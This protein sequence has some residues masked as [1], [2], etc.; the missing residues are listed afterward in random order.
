MGLSLRVAPIV[1]LRVVLQPEFVAGTRA[2][3]QGGPRGVVGRGVGHNLQAC[4]HSWM[5]S[6][7]AG[8]TGEHT[9]SDVSPAAALHPTVCASPCGVS[10]CQAV[11]GL[12]FGFKPCTALYRCYVYL[13]EMMLTGL[14]YNSHVYMVENYVAC[15]ACESDMSFVHTFGCLQVAFPQAVFFDTAKRLLTT[16]MQ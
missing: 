12:G 11:R 7:A 6:C 10:K 15:L 8:L 4:T 5:L 2:G 1:Q 9:Q 13:R 3:A 16:G 14:A